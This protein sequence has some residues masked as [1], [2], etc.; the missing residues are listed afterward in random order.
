LD[1]YYS[2][3]DELTELINNKKKLLAHKEKEEAR[4]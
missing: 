4:K 1:K 2:L 3:K